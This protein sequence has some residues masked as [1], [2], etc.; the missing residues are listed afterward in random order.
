MFFF[1]SEEEDLKSE[2]ETPV[3]PSVRLWPVRTP[4]LRNT[5]PCVCPRCDKTFDLQ[6]EMY[7]TNHR[8]WL[9]NSGGRQVSPLGWHMKEISII[10]RVFNGTYVCET[11]LTKK[12]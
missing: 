10:E 11:C 6:T 5:R 9:V 3:N 2:L 1:R 12:P 7:A 8:L 4:R